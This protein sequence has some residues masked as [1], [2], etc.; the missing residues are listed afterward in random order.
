M[1]S[2]AFLVALSLAAPPAAAP[3]PAV[4]AN[5]AFERL[6]KLE[7][8]WKT[9][10]K[11]G[12]VQY[13]ALRLIAAGT[14]VL[15]TNTAADRTTITSVT[16]YSF[17]G[18][19]LIATHYGSGGTSRLEFSGADAAALKFDSAVK[20]A[21]VGGLWLVVKQNKLR[22]EWTTRESGRDVKKALEL[23]SEYVDTLK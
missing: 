19:K 6:K 2:L 1:H 4:D 15:E 23:L 14:A 17:E 12:P 10:A 22:Q 18:S 21:R 7:G 3:A 13:V 20:D 16:V 9:D 5:A 11:D 8:A